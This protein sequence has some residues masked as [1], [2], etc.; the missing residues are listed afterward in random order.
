[1]AAYGIPEKLI[2][3]VQELYKN[4]QICVINN[5][6]QSKRLKLISGVKQ[7][8]NMSGFSVHTNADMKEKMQRITETAETTGLKINVN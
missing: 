3:I 4:S 2:R 8:C 6:V 1:M 5:G 7:G